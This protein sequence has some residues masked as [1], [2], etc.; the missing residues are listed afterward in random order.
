M[1]EK[2]YE[3][4]GGWLLVFT[5]SI[6]ILLGLSVTV[7]LGL[8]VSFGEL[9]IVTVFLLVAF[10]VP[11][12]SFTNILNIIY[13]KK[14]NADIRIRR[15]LLM[16]SIY[17]STLFFAVIIIAT[18]V[19]EVFFAVFGGPSKA[20]AIDI[21]PPIFICVG[22][23]IIYAAVWLRYFKNSERVKYYFNNV[24]DKYKNI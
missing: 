9:D 12:I 1:K 15:I 2:N 19:I 7:L 11:I 21:L 22:S 24:D 5:I 13:E 8:F 4:L 23:I 3:K 20:P 17:L 10:T 6:C 16:T 18:I 14:P